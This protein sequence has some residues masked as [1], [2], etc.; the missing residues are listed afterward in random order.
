MTTLQVFYMLVLSACHEG[1]ENGVNHTRAHFNL[2]V[3]NSHMIFLRRS[4]LRQVL[5]SRA[6]SFYSIF[7]TFKCICTTYL[8]VSIAPSHHS[9]GFLISAP[10]Q[11]SKT[12][13]PAK[14]QLQTLSHQDIEW[15]IWTNG[16]WLSCWLFWK[17]ESFLHLSNSQAVKF[18]SYFAR[19]R[20]VSAMQLFHKKRYLGQNLKN[21]L[22]VRVWFW[23]FGIAEWPVH[24]EMG[25]EQYW[26]VFS[27]TLF[28]Q[29]LRG[30]DHR[31]GHIFYQV[32]VDLRSSLSYNS[33][34]SYLRL[35]LGGINST[36]DASAGKIHQL[37]Q[38]N[39]KMWW[40][41]MHQQ[42]RRRFCT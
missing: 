21:E 15:G 20:Y 42:S 41:S 14:E 27:I 26:E 35:I 9:S 11:F 31:F 12:W 25:T 5:R 1:Y 40:N 38:M 7:Y 16:F 23:F 37:F 10:S 4:S 24:L 32:F 28:A 36:N 39:L 22:Q 19:S 3:L 18:R 6:Y 30:I 8:S 33:A 13:A 17:R 29:L 34:V 2:R